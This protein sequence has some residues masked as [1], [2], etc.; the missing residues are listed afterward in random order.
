[1][2][3][4]MKY[5]EAMAVDHFVQEDEKEKRH[6]IIWETT[7]EPDGFPLIDPIDVGTD[8]AWQFC[9]YDE[10]GKLHSSWRIH[11]FLQNTTFYVVWLDPDHQLICMDGVKDGKR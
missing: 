6:T 11:G 7:D 9:L 5:Y 1:M 2:L 10:R 4:K 3:S 8:T